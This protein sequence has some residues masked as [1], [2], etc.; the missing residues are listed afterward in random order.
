MQIDGSFSWNNYDRLVP[1]I[2]PAGSE[3]KGLSRTTLK[4]LDEVV[5]IPMKGHVNSLNVSNAVAIG[6]YCISMQL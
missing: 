2:I 1:Q 5:S 6:L 4:Q 3:G